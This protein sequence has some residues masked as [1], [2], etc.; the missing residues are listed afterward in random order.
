LLAAARS[1]QA[2]HLGSRGLRGRA[3]RARRP[4]APPRQRPP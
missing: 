1:V 3:E 2:H 4:G